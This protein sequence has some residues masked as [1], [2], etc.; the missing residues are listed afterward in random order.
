MA[1]AVDACYQAPEHEEVVVELALEYLERLTKAGRDTDIVWRLRRQL[2]GR[3]AAGQS[4]VE[5]VAGILV[6]KL[7]FVRCTTAPHFYWSSERMVALEL[8]M[9]DIHGAA[10]PTDVRQESHT[11]ISNDYDCRFLVRHEYNQTRNI[12]IC[13]EPIGTDRCEDETDPGVLSTCP[14]TSFSRR[15]SCVA[16][17]SGMAEYYAMCSTAEE[18]LHLRTILEHFGFSVNISFFSELVAAQV[19]ALTV[20]T[21]WLQEVVRETGL[22]TKLIASKAN[23]ADLGTK[24]L[25]VARLSALRGACGIVVPGELSRDVVESENELYPD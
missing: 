15:Q 13:C 4:L 8:H 7:G 12:W 5:H 22:Q 11:N 14:L 16:T 3:R 24:V 17:S 25:P 18:R 6:N 21:P 9:D 23:K 2:P 19:T 20:K 10:T 1:D